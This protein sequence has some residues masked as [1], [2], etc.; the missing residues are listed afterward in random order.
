MQEHLNN[1]VFF[2]SDSQMIQILNGFMQIRVPLKII[3]KLESRQ[4]YPFHLSNITIH[5]GF[6]L[7]TF[8]CFRS[9]KFANKSIKKKKNIHIPE[10]YF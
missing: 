10:R 5:T 7:F 6:Y 8:V 2:S 4:R 9:S 1:L 3:K